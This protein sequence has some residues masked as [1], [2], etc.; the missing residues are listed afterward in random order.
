MVERGVRTSDSCT[1]MVRG[2]L[3]VIFD[4]VYEAFGFDVDCSACYTTMPRL[5]SY[6]NSYRYVMVFSSVIVLLSTDDTGHITFV[7]H[8]ELQFLYNVSKMSPDWCGDLSNTMVQILDLCLQYAKDPLAIQSATM[9]A[10][11]MC[12]VPRKPAVEADYYQDLL[13]GQYCIPNLIKRMLG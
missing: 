10:F 13:P 4:M 1:I 7:A 2:D 9:S 12:I 5:K 6:P 3:D 8:Y 11:A